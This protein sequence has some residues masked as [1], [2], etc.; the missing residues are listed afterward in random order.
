MAVKYDDKSIRI[1]LHEI[2][3]VPLLTRE[4][5]VALARRIQKG[6][7]QARELM[8][9]ANLRL[10]VKIAHDYVRLDVPLL[11]LI[12]EG[13]IGLIK[14]V[15][16]F[17]PDNGAK[18]STYAAWWIKQSIKRALVNQGR[19]IR[20]PAH[21]VG[22]LTRMYMKGHRVSESLG[23]EPTDEELASELGVTVGKIAHWRTVA[24]RP[25]SLSAPLQEGH[26][27]VCLGEV[28]A[29]ESAR[30]PY[31][32]IQDQELRAEAEHLFMKLDRR[33]REVLTRRFGLKGTK[34]E[35]LNAVGSRLNI[36]RERVRQIQAT[37]VG[38][39]RKMIDGHP[40]RRIAMPTD[41]GIKG[42]NMPRKVQL[43][44]IPL[45]NPRRES[46]NRMLA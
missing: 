30:K 17:D 13:N 9:R 28:I 33:E 39:L 26:E 45:R 24:A 37:A 2:G 10:V 38:K 4:E 15:D 22:K 46:A 6:D 14:A 44:P 32:A 11:D 20:L 40:A 3:Q 7:D 5:E 21:M 35:T 27:S 8:I 1:Y 16:R 42:P 19:T 31:E 36:T 23:R 41:P 43:R 25:A 18:F 12:S 29:D 34:S